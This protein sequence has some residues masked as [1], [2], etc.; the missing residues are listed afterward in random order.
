MEISNLFL[1]VS[2]IRRASV[3]GIKKGSHH[4]MGAF[5]V[6]SLSVSG[7]SDLHACDLES[8]GHAAS[9]SIAFIVCRIGGGIQGRSA[10]P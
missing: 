1:E 6:V 10:V 2:T 3:V 7:G 9:G 8:Q 5:S 4:M